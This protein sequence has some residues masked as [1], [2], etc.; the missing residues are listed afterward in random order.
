MKKNSLLS[1]IENELLPSTSAAA[2]FVVNLLGEPVSV[3]LAD[4]IS[5]NLV[6]LINDLIAGSRRNF[7][8]KL[9]INKMLVVG[10]FIVPMPG[11]RI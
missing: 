9:S 10:N 11:M 3:L 1:L 7:Y 8:L 5:C 2:A 4:S 6:N